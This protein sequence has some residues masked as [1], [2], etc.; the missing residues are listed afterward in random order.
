MSDSADYEPGGGTLGREILY[1]KDF[2][3]AVLYI[4]LGTGTVVASLRYEFGSPSNMGPGFFPVVLGSLLAMIGGIIAVRAFAK[5]DRADARVGFVNW[6]ALALITASTVVFGLLL[7][8]VGVLIAL[9]LLM[10]MGAAASRHFR[11]ELRAIIGMLLLS[12]AC[13]LVFVI[14]LGVPMPLLGSLFGG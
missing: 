4:V 3:S 11:I 5:G 9:P 8:L 2:W 1:R 10:L 12:G 7:P 13:A 6:K 14:G